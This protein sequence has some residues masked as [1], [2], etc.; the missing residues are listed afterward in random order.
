ML[1]FLL[2]KSD[3][4]IMLRILC[5]AALFVCSA[6]GARGLRVASGRGSHGQRAVVMNF[7]GLAA[8]Y[9]NSSFDLNARYCIRHGLKLIRGDGRRRYTDGRGVAWEKLP[10]LLE[11]L[12]DRRYEW[13][14]WVDADAAFYPQAPDLLTMITKEHPSADFVFSGDI[15][16][17][18]VNTGVFA[19]RNTPYSR[20]FLRRWAFDM[21]LFGANPNP[22]WWEQGVFVDMAKK[23]ILNISQHSHTY[24]YGVLQHFYRH[25]LTDG[26]L[27]SPPFLLHFAGRSGIRGK[28]LGEA[29][30]QQPPSFAALIVESQA[31]ADLARRS[32]SSGS[33]DDQ[34]KPLL[35][36]AGQSP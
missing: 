29:L 30:A 26:T 24:A 28:S 23:N 12:G 15:G 34:L 22:E 33:S 11:L 4:P 21:E 20:A 1:S 6:W 35:H 36:S 18:N 16:D 2:Y 3:V 27:R 13:L 10:L 8:A 14:V 31:I 17:R 25:E 9:G 5:C 19:V 7:D 32:A